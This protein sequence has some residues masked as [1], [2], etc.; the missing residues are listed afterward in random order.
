[1]ENE[2][3]ILWQTLRPIV[4][5]LKTSPVAIGVLANLI[6]ELDKRY[7]INEESEMEK[8]MKTFDHIYNKKQSSGIMT[9]A[10]AVEMI[11]KME[12]QQETEDEE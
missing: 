10:D 5:R 2:A 8:L 4:T 11:E 6:P 12:K 1:M 7:G 9:L 3:K